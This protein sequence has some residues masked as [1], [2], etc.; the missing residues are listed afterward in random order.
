MSADPTTPDE[1]QEAVDAASVCLAVD[2]ARKYGLVTGGP[3]ID[4][5][6]CEEIL[7]RGAELDIEPRPVEELIP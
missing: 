2:A 3:E 6:R 5:D 1:W 7:R 4:L